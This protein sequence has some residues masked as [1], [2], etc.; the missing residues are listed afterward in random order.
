MD[1]AIR[2]IGN[3][4]GII[5]PALALKQAGI[6]KIADMQVKDGCIILKA[7]HQTRKGWL[8][9]IHKDPPDQNETVFMEGAED[10]EL[11]EEWTW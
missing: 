2:E 7:V 3:S 10:K 1:I 8:D 4:K 6:Q 9:Q 11:L 5:I